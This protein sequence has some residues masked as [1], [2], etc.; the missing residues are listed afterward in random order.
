MYLVHELLRSFLVTFL[1]TIIQWKS[2][3]LIINYGLT[4]ML[5]LLCIEF[6]PSNTLPRTYRGA[7]AVTNQLGL[8]YNLIYVHIKNCILFRKEYADLDY[9]PKCN[10]SRWKDVKAKKTMR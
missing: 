7:K 3:H 8:G 2:K 5:Q 6:P 4:N 1:V 9:C 10:E